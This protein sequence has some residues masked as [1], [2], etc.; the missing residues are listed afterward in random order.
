MGTYHV[1]HLLSVRD[2]LVH[3]LI[4]LRVHTEAFAL[5]R[6]L[7]IIF[8]CRHARIH[9]RLR[10]LSHAVAHPTVFVVLLEILVIIAVTDLSGGKNGGEGVNKSSFF[11]LDVRVPY[12]STICV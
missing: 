8:L 5:V 1:G 4:D 10:I 11:G 2:E 3:Q 7:G 12:L 6:H 9:D